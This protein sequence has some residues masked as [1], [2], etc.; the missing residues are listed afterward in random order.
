MPTT[1]TSYSRHPHFVATTLKFFARDAVGNNETVQT[2]VYTIDVSTPATTAS[3][4]GG[5]YTVA[6]NV[7]LTTSETAT[8]YF[9]IDGTP[10]TTGSPQYG[11]PIP[12]G[13]GATTLKFF[14]RDAAGNQEAVRTEN[15]TIDTL[16]PTVTIDSQ[17]ANPTA[18]ATAN[19]T[20]SSNEANATFQCQI[21]AGA[22][23]VCTSPMSITPPMYSHTFNVGAIDAPGTSR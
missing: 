13:E 9:T 12:L 1:P 22:F 18:S 21:D 15:Y 16:R 6:T 14:A 23:D 19:F 8:I 10:P 4:A 3:P 7:T 2:K 20:F 17:P 5:S 11:T